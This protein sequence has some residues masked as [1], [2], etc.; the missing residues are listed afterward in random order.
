MGHRGFGSRV[1]VAVACAVVTVLVFGCSAKEK[2]RPPEEKVATVAAAVVAS[3]DVAAFVVYADKSAAVDNNA[4]VTGG[5]I[6]VRTVT[7]DVLVDGAELAVTNNA[8]APGRLYADAVLLR[9]SSVGAISTNKLLEKAKPS[10]GAVSAFDAASMPALPAAGTVAA[11]SGSFVVATN[12]TVVLAPG[13]KGDVTVKPNAVLR[14]SGG[15]YQFASLTL[16]SNTRLEAV[17]ASEVRIAGRLDAAPKS[18]FGPAQGSG[19]T[20]KGLRIEVN[21]SNGGA[22]VGSKPAACSFGPNATVRALVLVPNGT[23]DL[24]QNSAAQGALFGQAVRIEEN[25]TVVFEDGFAPTCPASC[26]DGNACTADSCKNGAC[27]HDPV[28]NGTSCN[29]N[30]AC[31]QQDSCQAGVCVGASPVQCAA[32]DQCHAAGTCDTATGVC[33]NPA[34]PDGSSCDDGSACTQSDSCQAGACVGSSPVV[35]SAQD[36]CHDVGSC[37]P[38]TGTCSNPAKPDGMSCSDGSAC[39]QPDICQAGACVGA[40]PVVCGPLDQCH[41][42]GSCNPATGTCSNPPAVDGTT[43]TD[44]N[45]CTQTD[46]CI[47]G[48]CSGANPVQCAAL[49]QCHDP[50]TCDAGTGV[51]SNPAKPN[52]AS[53]SDGSA[54]TQTDSCQAGACVGANPVICTA[55]DQC[56]NA[57]TCD[58][59]SGTC[60]NPAK[61]DGS[62]C[63]DGNACTQTDSC[64]AGAC[65]GA[66]PVMCTAVD[67]C[68]DAGS[69]DTATGVCS[70]PPKP[71]G[72]ACSDGNACT[73]TDQ[74]QA[75][76]CTGSNPVSCTAQDQCHDAGTCDAATGVCSNPPKPNGA[77]CS[78][79]NACTQSDS[80]QAGACVGSNSVVCSAKDACH[81][82]GSCVPATGI[83]SNPAKVDGASCSSNLCLA[84]QSCSAGVCGGGSPVNADDGIACTID[85]CDPQTGVKHR[86]C[87]TLDR[88][89]STTLYEATKFLFTGNDPI[90]TGVAPGTID[91]L[92]I[93][94]LRGKVKTIAGDALAGVSVTIVKLSTSAADYGQ[95]QT[96]ADG[97]FTMAANGGGQLTIRY[98]KSGYLE[99]QRQLD[100]PWQDYVQLPD[101]VLTPAD[102][103]STVINLPNSSLQVHR[104][105]IVSD[106]DGGR[107]A[108]LLVQPGTTAQMIFPDGSGQSISTMTVRAT[109]FTVGASGREAMPQLL[110]P[111]SG[112]TYAV[113][114]NADEAVAAGAKS[115]TFNQPL[116]FYLEN[117]LGLPVGLDVPLGSY[118]RSGGCWKAEPNGRVVKILAIQGGA[119]VLDTDG[120]GQPES[121]ATLTAMGVTSE[122]LAKLAELYPAGQTLWRVPVSHFTNPQDMNFPHKC[123]GPCPNPPG[124]GGGP[125]PGPGGGSPGPGPGPG[126]NCQDDTSST[127]Y[128]QSQTLAESVPVVGT[129]Y[130]LHYASHRVV[131]SS[132]SFRYAVPLT[133]ADV[134]ASLAQIDLLIDI[135]G[136]HVEQSYVC[137]GACTPNKSYDFSWDGRDVFGRALQGAERAVFRVRYFYD[138]VYTVPPPALAASFAAAGLDTTNIPSRTHILKETTTERM[139]GGWNELPAGLGAWSLDVHH[140][141]DPVGKVLHLGNGHERRVDTMS[142][143]VHT[144]ASGLASPEG[145]KVAPDGAIYFAEA[146]GPF[147]RKIAPDGA[148]TTVAGGGATL[149]DGGPATQA[150]L[151]TPLDVAL[152]PDGTVCIADGN[153]YRIRCIDK[154]TGII[155]TRAG[156]GQ[157][158][159]SGDGGPA[160]QAMIEQPLGIA[161]GPDCGLYV[162]GGVHVRR[163]GPDGIITTV[164]GSGNGNDL[165]LPR[166]ATQAYINGPYGLAFSPDGSLYISDFGFNQ[167]YR[168]GTDGILSVAAGTGS[169]GASGDGGPAMQA[170]LSNVRHLAAGADG[171]IYAAVGAVGSPPPSVSGVRRI[172]PDGVITK[173]AGAYVPA[174]WNAQVYCGEDGPAAAAQLLVVTGIAL[175]APGQGAALYLAD[176]SASR[177][178]RVKSPLPGVAIGNLSVPSED[179]SQLFVFNGS[180]RHLETRDTVVGAALYTFGY[181]AEGRLISVTDVN[182]L[183]TTIQHDGAGNPTKIVGP[184]GQVTTL[185]VDANGY[186]AQITNPASESFHVTYTA[187]GLLSDF[188][189]PRGFT[190]QHAYDPVS[191]RFV[192]STD[193]VGA[194]RSYARTDTATGHVVK[195]TS[196][197]GLVTTYDLAQGADGAWNFTNTFPSGLV[198]TQTAATDGTTTTKLPDGTTIATVA[199]PDPRFGELAPATTTTT[200]TPLGLTQ[201]ITT[202]RLMTLSNP[203]DPL[204]PATL[205]EKI[206]V[207]GKTSVRSFDAAT[208]VWTLTTPVGRTST[209]TIDALAR[210]TQSATSGLTAV[211]FNYDNQGRLTTTTQGA[212]QSMLGYD[213][214]GWL[215]TSTDPLAQTVTFT[216]DAAGRI[217]ATQ[218]PD[219]QVIGQGYDPNGNLTSVTPPG[220]PAHA[221]AY[222]KVNLLADYLPPDAGFSPRD[223]QWSYDGDRELTA[224]LR[225]DG[226]TLATGYDS[227]GRVGS[228]TAPTETRTYSYS[229]ATGQ[230]LS[231]AAPNVT[232]SYSWDGSLLTGMTWSGA[233][234]GSVEFTRDDDFRVSMETV[235]AGG[236]VSIQYDLDSLV[237]QAGDLAVA[238]SS[239]NALLTGTTLDQLSDS[240]SY[241]GFGELSSYEA[242]FGAN[243]LY[244]MVFERDALGRIT[245]KTE[246]IGATTTVFE[247][248][249]DLVGRLKQVKENGVVARSYGYDANGNRLNKTDLAGTTAGSYDDQDRL[250][251]YGALNFTYTKAGELSSEYNSA[252]NQTTTYVYDVFGNLASVTLPNAD[253]ITYI[254]DPENRRSQKK[255]NGVVERSWLYK[256]QLRPIAELDAAGNVV[257]RFV[258]ALGKNVPDY[259]IKGGVKYR[260]VTDQVG[261]VRLVVN[262]ATGAV[263]QRIDYD[264]F[265]VVLLD[266]SPGFQP[267]GFAGGLYDPDTGLV[268]FG[269]RD[270]DAGTGRWTA[271]DP[272]LFAGGASN[273]YEYSGNDPQN[274]T[275]PDGMDKCQKCHDEC[276]EQFGKCLKDCPA[277][278]PPPKD[279][280]GGAPAKVP[281]LTCKDKCTN[282]WAKCSEVCNVEY[283]PSNKKPPPPTP[284]QQ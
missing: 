181:D 78:D 114:L 39:T 150:S 95:T 10:H 170:T 77:A 283:C 2:R 224:M 122:E 98:S 219:A 199:T 231:I 5:A 97:V 154:D 276:F 135:A 236:P 33:S 61:V 164:A 166:R 19:L 125:G 188:T 47:S 91:P 72:T 103:A 66:N 6:G 204:H 223:T 263:A 182:G 238:R 268:R 119:A 145:I 28:P 126:G 104:G 258:Y 179:G 4:K 62:S 3:A 44:G 244:K 202:E 146:S 158:G 156:T 73:Q 230:L 201:K 281:V 70:N 142:A 88:T 13:A 7:S 168:L 113:E 116:A 278:P 124:G 253:V 80:C 36:Q 254:A 63:S 210:T 282:T 211:S 52:G 24:G 17:A 149:G 233:V 37:N 121:A 84:G 129:S 234:N 31:T 56:H 143:T 265:G 189:D 34:M 252:T 55:S 270:Y 209:T 43:C 178:L 38:G 271:K 40:N 222:D 277:E 90:Q 260:L 64:Q 65:V 49:D 200:K 134:P 118:G 112:Y 79:G 165:P 133:T 242:L 96:A 108:T 171:S 117:F 94:V 48:T 41:E 12:A 15:L 128:C 262:T 106:A 215:A 217:T 228:L 123:S 237:S 239:Q 275:D 82:A 16:Q 241:S 163:I 130:T 54:C 71:N 127:V 161:F 259:M 264:E 32:Q 67:P 26:D 176:H 229:A 159:Y 86:S 89:V 249:Y 60:S 205:T 245:K 185:G 35:C 274:V 1:G 232:L 8:S 30:N 195:K 183:V 191:G 76:T 212:R 216:R 235:D 225:P 105:S 14:L 21:G 266:T 243:S 42:A 250:L 226:L 85:T 192:K 99:V 280:G 177:L 167:I 214:S 59:S 269:A 186:L 120:D 175:G 131:D 255:V 169:S 221:L 81:D 75:G 187:G 20:A 194:I 172:G 11:G 173:V 162:A 273:L 160:T 58:S 151:G 180:G 261:T 136:R 267:F 153:H 193:P 184:Y 157:L 18:S 53:C 107:R 132:G 87:S 207:N 45:A 93:A 23:L 102:V 109:E 190:T 279:K 284:C 227:A 27:V 139:L 147:V 196:A 155:T 272:I 74:C 115:V 203:D 218:R 69:C 92:R 174:C 256:D 137:P 198:A 111:T 213:A 251:V 46:V 152:A 101:V 100:A 246:T 148:I 57:G 141:Y 29:D 22:T 208:K 50:G 220:R 197:T 110:P 144:V 138:A 240:Y 257:S 140:A 247:Y 248:A 83:C 25:A 51:C 9:G 68:H 206:T